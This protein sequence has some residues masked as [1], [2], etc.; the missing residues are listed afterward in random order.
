MMPRA[1]SSLIFIARG[2]STTFPDYEKT[3]NPRK[4]LCFLSSLSASAELYEPLKTWEN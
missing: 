3:K 4:N 2:P 1:L